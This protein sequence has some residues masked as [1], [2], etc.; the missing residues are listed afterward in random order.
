MERLSPHRGG[1]RDRTAKSLL[2]AAAR[3]V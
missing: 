2:S 1:R 3:H